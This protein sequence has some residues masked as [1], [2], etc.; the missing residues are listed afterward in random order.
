MQEMLPPGSFSQPLEISSAPHTY[1]AVYMHL[2]YHLDTVVTCSVVYLSNW[3]M[4]S[5]F[6]LAHQAGY[7]SEDFPARSKQPPHSHRIFTPQPQYPLGKPSKLH[8]RQDFQHELFER[9]ERMLS[10]Q[11]QKVA[12]CRSPT[13]PPTKPNPSSYRLHLHYP[14]IISPG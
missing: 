3:L 7:L 1:T 13:Q 2:L 8:L 11:I 4:S 9:L 12:Q 10:S 14:S 6:F 5:G